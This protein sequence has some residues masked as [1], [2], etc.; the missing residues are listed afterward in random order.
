MSTAGRGDEASAGDERPAGDEALTGGVVNDSVVRRGGTVRRA[1]GP[2]TPTVHAVLR[3]LEAVGFDAAPRVVGI[4]D[5]VEVLTFVHGETAWG[6][7]H[8]RLLG[9]D[10]AMH[11]VGELLAR[12]HRAI[13]GVRLPVPPVWRFPEMQDDAQRFAPGDAL[14]VCHNDA[15]GWNLVVDGGRPALIDWDAIGWRPAIWDVAYAVAGTV[16]LSPAWADLGWEEPP[17]V[18]ARVGALCDGYGLAAADRARL[19]RGVV[20]RITSSYEHLRRRAEA[21]IAPWDR[22]WATGHG[23]RWA[24]MLACARSC[25]GD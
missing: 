6:P 9:S 20:A 10:D 23:D 3:H 1:A 16:P 18:A 14:I 2:W 22:L 25:F 17:D 13:V 12:Y 15:A 7:A 4:D 19:G 21:G 24:A 8:H 5:G 11:A